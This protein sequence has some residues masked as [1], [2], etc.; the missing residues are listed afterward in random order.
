MTTLA[1]VRRVRHNAI[2]LAAACHFLRFVEINQMVVFRMFTRRG[3]MFSVMRVRA[4]ILGNHKGLMRRSTRVCSN[5]VSRRASETQG[6]HCGAAARAGAA[7]ALPMKVR[8]VTFIS[9]KLR[10]TPSE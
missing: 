5:K 7:I 6:L 10:L 3:R 8:L 9:V 1:L 2:R 4:L